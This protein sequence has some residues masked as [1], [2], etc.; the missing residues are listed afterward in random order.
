MSPTGGDEGDE[1]AWV[2]LGPVGTLVGT[3]STDVMI[4]LI[5]TICTDSTLSHF[6]DKAQG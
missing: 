1:G 3:T 2:S 4:P 5:V 6:C